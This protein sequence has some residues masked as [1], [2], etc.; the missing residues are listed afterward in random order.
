MRGIFLCYCF[1]SGGIK[2]EYIEINLTQAY[3]VDVFSLLGGLHLG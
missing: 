1:E 3:V 2:P